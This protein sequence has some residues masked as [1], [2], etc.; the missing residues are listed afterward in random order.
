MTDRVGPGEDDEA[1]LDAT[2]GIEPTLIEAE[3]RQAA[4]DR[5]VVDDDHTADW[6]LRTLGP[7]VGAAPNAAAQAVTSAGGR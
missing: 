7:R 6:A 2:V 5:L 4:A 3:P 1:F